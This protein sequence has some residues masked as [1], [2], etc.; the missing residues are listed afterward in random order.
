MAHVHIPALLRHAT[1]GRVWVE[2]PGAT[3]REV[4]EALE[5]TYP[6]LQGLL[7]REGRLQPGLAVAIDGEMSSMGLNEETGPETEVQFLTA[8]S[9]GAR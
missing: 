9:G 8:I 5:A 6:V 4:V 7:V 3:V 1:E 2:A